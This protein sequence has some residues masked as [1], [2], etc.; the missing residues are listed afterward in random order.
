MPL[1]HSRD[2]KIGTSGFS[3]PGPSPKGWYGAFYPEKKLNGFDELKHYSQIFDTCEINQTFYRPPSAKTTQ[4]WVDKTS[5]GLLFAVKPW[6]K[7]TQPMKISRMKSEDQWGP[8]SEKDFDE[9]RA[10]IFPLAEAGKLGA[11]LLQY[12]ASFKWSR[13]TLESVEST[14]KRFYDYPKV[15]EFAIAAG[16][17]TRRRRGARL[18][19]IGR[20]G[21]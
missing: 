8:A 20:V 11:L 10:G 7:F 9:F 2:I 6:Q 1:D 4:A 21:R 5:D 14:L 15:I 3:Y 19:N 18:R 17:K 12:P 16:V 13:A